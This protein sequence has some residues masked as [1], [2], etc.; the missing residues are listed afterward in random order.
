MSF[1]SEGKWLVTGSEDGTIRIWDLR[2][3]ISPR[4]LKPEAHNIHAEV[5]KCIERMITAPPA[6]FYAFFHEC[7]LIPSNSQ[8]EWCLCASE[9]RGADILRSSGLHQAMGFIGK[10]LL[11]WV[12]MLRTRL[13]LTLINKVVET[14]AG[15]VPI[16]SV[17]LASDGSCLVAGNNKVLSRFLMICCL[18]SWFRANAT[19][20]KLTRRSQIYLVTR[21]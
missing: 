19:C 11:A 21:Q 3:V 8:S 17:S 7:L 2:C 9:S 6:S 18:H 12:G 13:E 15:D 16:R 10:S 20:G 1:H 4:L 5:P 14:P